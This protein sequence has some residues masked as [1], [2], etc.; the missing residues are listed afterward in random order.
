MAGH[1][2]PGQPQGCKGRTGAEGPAPG[3]TEASAGLGLLSV[4]QAGSSPRQS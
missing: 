4:R 1:R 2:K 3:P